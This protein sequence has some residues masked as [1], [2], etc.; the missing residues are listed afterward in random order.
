VEA[1][2]D[3]A[4]TAPRIDMIWN[5]IKDLDDKFINSVTDTFLA[6]NKFAPL[7]AEFFELARIERASPYRD[8]DLPKTAKEV[9]PIENSIFSKEDIAEMCN[10]IRKKIRGEISFK[11]LEDY[12]KMIENIVKQKANGCGECNEGLLFAY[13]KRNKHSSAIVFKCGCQLGM[14]RKEN[15]TLWQGDLNFRLTP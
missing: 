7:P 5:R 10:M 4:F 6:S 1:F 8:F 2:G 15:Y 11:E 14:R 3:K 13:D 12:G 9:H